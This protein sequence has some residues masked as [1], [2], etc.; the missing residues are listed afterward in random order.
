MKT[1]VVEAK[2]VNYIDYNRKLIEDIEK[3]M[4]A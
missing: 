2:P 3:M 1:I 4:S